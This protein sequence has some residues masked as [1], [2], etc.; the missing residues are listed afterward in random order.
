MHGRP[1]LRAPDSRNRQ[2]GFE[3]KAFLPRRGSLERGDADGIA[4]QRRLV[5][6][7]QRSR[8]R[9]AFGAV[10]KEQ[11]VVG[12]RVLQGRAGQTKRAHGRGATLSANERQCV[13]LARGELAQY[14]R[15]VSAIRQVD[16]RSRNDLGSRLVRTRDEHHRIGRGDGAGDSR[17]VQ[18]PD[19]FNA[20]ASGEILLYD[21]P[22]LFGDRASQ[23]DARSPQGAN[24]THRQ[25]RKARLRQAIS[26]FNAPSSRRRKPPRNS[27]LCAA[28]YRSPETI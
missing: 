27:R 24:R 5:E 25:P 3:R 1:R 15:F 10:Q 14:N 26:T 8:S 21:S 17:R 11:S 16:H 18:Q 28:P 2:G 6:N 12:R 22:A 4:A 20:V 7:I 23:Q 13:V 9:L 19:A